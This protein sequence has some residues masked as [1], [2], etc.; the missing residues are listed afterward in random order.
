MKPF[1]SFVGDLTL[2]KAKYCGI[3]FTNVFPFTLWEGQDPPLR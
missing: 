2:P 3:E 1:S